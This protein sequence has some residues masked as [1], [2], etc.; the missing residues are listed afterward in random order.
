MNFILV[1]SDHS[2]PFDLQNL[3][4][5]TVDIQDLIYAGEVSPKETFKLLREEWGMGNHLASA[6]VG[7]CGGHLYDIHN[8]IYQLI[9]SKHDFLCID[10]EMIARVE[11]CCLYREECCK[12]SH[13]QVSFLLDLV[14]N[15][16]QKLQRLQASITWMGWLQGMRKYVIFLVFS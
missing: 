14:I 15:T 2:F 1:S 9:Q 11:E 10:R 12:N 7:S 13:L 6:F 5:N 8:A 4:F 3:G 16:T